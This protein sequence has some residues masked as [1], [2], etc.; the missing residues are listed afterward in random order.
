MFISGFPN[1]GDTV[2]NSQSIPSMHWPP[3]WVFSSVQE[4]HPSLVGFQ[5]SPNV[6]ADISWLNYRHLFSGWIGYFFKQMHPPKDYSGSTGAPATV[7]GNHSLA[8]CHYC[9]PNSIVWTYC[10]LLMN[11]SQ[12]AVTYG[13]TETDMCFMPL[14]RCHSYE[15]QHFNCAKNVYLVLKKKHACL[16]HLTNEDDLSVYM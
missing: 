1:Q 12:H 4:C 8:Q 2:K 6:E 10:V 7:L 13:H 3:L 14:G 11:K 9:H 16:T 15:L 5:R